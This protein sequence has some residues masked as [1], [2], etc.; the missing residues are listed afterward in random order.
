MGVRVWSHSTRKSAWAINTKLVGVQVQWP[1]GQKVNIL[2]FPNCVCVV[3]GRQIAGQC[4]VCMPILYRC[5]ECASHCHTVCWRYCNGI[6]QSQMEI[7]PSHNLAHISGS[8]VHSSQQDVARPTYSSQDDE[9]CAPCIHFQYSSVIRRLPVGHK[10]T[11]TSFTKP[12]AAA[13]A[14]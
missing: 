1:W 9:I 5:S 3:D 12:A 4:G 6:M 8:P 14:G 11:S 13:A 2:G 10:P 7:Q